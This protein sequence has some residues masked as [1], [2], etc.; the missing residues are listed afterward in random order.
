MNEQKPHQAIWILE[1]VY[2][3][4]HIQN[5]RREK[6]KATARYKITNIHAYMTNNTR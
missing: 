6:K 1:H 4:T 5:E 3:Q 2:S